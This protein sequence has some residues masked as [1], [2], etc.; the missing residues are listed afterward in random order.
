[1]SSAG[2]IP[3]RPIGSQGLKSSAQGL[4]CMSMVG[5]Y[6]DKRAPSN[7]EESIAVIHRFRELTEGDSHVFLDTADV[8]GPELSEKLVGAPHPS[9]ARSH[10]GRPRLRVASNIQP[11]T[12]IDTGFSAAYV[13]LQGMN[14]PGHPRQA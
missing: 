4:G 2:K 6:F 10:A 3:V 14:I 11:L 8:Y 12:L 1:M 5:A 7:D 9:Y 13:Y